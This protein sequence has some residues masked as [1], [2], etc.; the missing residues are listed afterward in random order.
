M[1]PEKI[2]KL[3][4]D[5]REKYEH[6]IM[7]DRHNQFKNLNELEQYV[8]QNSKYSI[9]TSK[10]KSMLK[11]IFSDKYDKQRLEYMIRLA[12]RV[13]KGEIEE[14][15]ASVAVGQILVDQIVKPQLKDTKK[16]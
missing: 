15:K 7:N 9:I 4:H 5:L 10:Y 14:Q 16:S 12:N 1:D 6:L 8:E 3:V 13:H 11:I 2:I